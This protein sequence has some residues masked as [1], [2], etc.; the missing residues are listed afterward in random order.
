MDAGDEADPS[1]APDGETLAYASDRSGDYEIYLQKVSGGPA[2]NLTKD[3][4]DDVHP[5]F[6]PDGQSIAFV[7]TSAEVATRSRTAGHACR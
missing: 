3:P 6:S 5:S 7:S 4:A 1:F 2:I